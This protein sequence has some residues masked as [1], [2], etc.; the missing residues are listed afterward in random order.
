MNIFSDAFIPIRKYLHDKIAIKQ[1]ISNLSEFENVGSGQVIFSF[2]KGETDNNHLLFYSNFSDKEPQLIP[3]TK[4]SLENNYSFRFGSHNNIIEKIKEKSIPFIE[5][6]HIISGMNIGGVKDYFLA[7]KKEN[8]TYHKAILSG[9]IFRYFTDYPNGLQV[10]NPRNKYIRFDKTI[11]K[12]IWDNNLGTPSI[13]EDELKFTQPKLL[14]RRPLTGDGVLAASF[15]EDN[16]EYSDVTVY[17]INETKLPL[18]SLLGIIN[19]KLAT[20]YCK[21]SGIIRFEKG[22]Q[23]Q[24]T[25]N[26]FKEFP[27]KFDKNIFERIFELVKRVLSLKKNNHDT[28]S[29]EKEID[30]LVYHLY[31]L[32]YDE[33]KIIDKDFWLS[34]EEYEKIKMEKAGTV[35]T[36]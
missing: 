23:P 34:E 7:D 15:S 22:Q 1:I 11:E 12:Y 6:A 32:T 10:R 2:S 13:G 19:S 24:I 26:R 28:T 17:I 20:Y 27:I 8:E 21:E 4:I 33:V 30:V 9:N 35:T 25:I 36:T 14:L 16:D 3:Q 5:S 29:L 31:E 18:K